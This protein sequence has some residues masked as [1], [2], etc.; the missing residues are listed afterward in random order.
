M[1]IEK[2]SLL[3]IP[4]AYKPSK[5]YSV[6]P[7]NG[8][9]DFSFSRASTATRVNKEGLM[10]TV[11]TEVP[12]L[13]YTNSTCPCLLLEPQSTNK[14]EYSSNFESTYQDWVSSNAT[15]A[16]NF[17]TAPDGTTESTKLTRT[18]LTST[19]RLEAVVLMTGGYATET[20]TA[21][22][23]VKNIDSTHFLFRM[24]L[25]ATSSNYV[26]TSFN[27]STQELILE[28]SSGYTLKGLKVDVLADGWFRLS[29]TYENGG[30]NQDRFQIAPSNSA[31]RNSVTANTSV[32][33]W[34]AQF[35]LLNYASS[36]IPTNGSAVTRVVDGCEIASGLENTLNTSE[37]TLFLDVE[38]ARVSAPSDFERIILTD[39]TFSDA[40]SIDNYGGNWRVFINANANS[41]INLNIAPVTAN[42][43]VKFAIAYSSNQL[44]I[45]FNGNAIT[46][47]SGTYAR[48][49]FLNSFRFSNASGGN[50]WQGKIYQTACFNEALS[51]AELQEL[52]TL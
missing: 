22:I 20:N 11:G 43:R 49:T 35:E 51:D 52:T 18:S 4:S 27:F 19:S 39:S 10:E 1:S 21:S 37:G 29:V 26:D 2:A 31:N 14:A 8:D 45:S 3:L 17:S 48:S 28:S 40:L 50:K 41:L 44:R 7:S 12:R 5:L 23:Y 30:Y 34:G 46:T 13:D 24:E 6:L 16:A 25:G 42:E 9:G 38:V 32:E 47:T 33:I 15:T 36:Y